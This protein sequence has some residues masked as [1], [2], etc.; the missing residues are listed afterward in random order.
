M[1]RDPAQQRRALARIATELRLLRAEKSGNCV[2]NCRADSHIAVKR[3]LAIFLDAKKC[4]GA[5]DPGDSRID[6]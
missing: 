5:M 2:R 1:E 4:R 3:G 6:D